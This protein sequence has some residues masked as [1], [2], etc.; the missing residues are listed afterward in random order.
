MASDIDTSINNEDQPSHT[1]FKGLGA[2]HHRDF[3]L[4][5]IGLLVSTVGSWMQSMAQGWL[6]YQLTGSEMQLGLVT[7]MGTFPVLFITLQAGVIADRFDKRRIIT[8]TQTLAA[9]QALILGLLTI[10]HIVRVWHILAL[11]AFAGFINA[12]DMPTRQAMTVELV[13]E[14]DLLQAVT[15]N[16][17]VFNLARIIGP[18][19]AGIVIAKYSTGACFIVNSISYVAIIFMLLIIHPKRSKPSDQD[20]PIISQIR[21]GVQYVIHSR[22]LRDLVIMT[23]VAS[24]FLLQY[25]TLLPAFAKK[26]LHVG[27]LGYGRMMSAIGFGALGAALSTAM[28]GHLF[29]QG[30]IIMAGSFIT[31][32]GVIALSLS[33]NFA[34]SI[35]CLVM[36]GFGM[37]M[38]LAVSNSLLQLSSPEN[39]RGRVLSIR[40]LMFVGLAPV[41]ALLAGALAEYLGV[42]LSVFI[43]AVIF[44]VTSSYL[45]FT[46]NTVR[47][48]I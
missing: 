25:P 39:M 27:A 32:L 24:L 48:A 29:K 10:F 3:L 33:H 19:I 18:A 28:F 20:E 9:V 13:G 31:P 16:S 2:L 1:K 22:L 36:T 34:L 42:Q 26:V 8:I 40:T 30:K 14:E 47:G 43:G 7:A 4:F 17:S 44:L 21:E 35:A 46:S 41:G 12:V 37:M 6:V 45:L 38:F 5:W 11:A 23:A 15:L